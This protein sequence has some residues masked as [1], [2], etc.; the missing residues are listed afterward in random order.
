M[1]RV[2]YDTGQFDIE[3]N[4]VSSKFR[5]AGA[6]APKKAIDLG[7]ELFQYFIDIRS[8]SS[9]FSIN[10]DVRKKRIMSFI[11][12]IWTVRHT[13]IK[14]CGIDPEIIMYDQ[15]LLHRNESS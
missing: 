11:K 13:F 3:E 15:M 7:N 1:W 5:V 8:S 10:A 14:L 12:S 2:A 9:R 6:G 4:D